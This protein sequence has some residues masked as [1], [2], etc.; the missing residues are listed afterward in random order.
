MAVTPSSAST[1]MIMRAPLIRDPASR[2]TAGRASGAMSLRVDVLMDG[3]LRNLLGGS[4]GDRTF[5]P[6]SLGSWCKLAPIPLFCQGF[7]ARPSRHAPYH[8]DSVAERS[9]GP[10]TGG[11]PLFHARLQHRVAV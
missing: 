11:G 4:E 2:W 1:C 8:R 3:V 7:F 6:N 5:E 10:D 9:G